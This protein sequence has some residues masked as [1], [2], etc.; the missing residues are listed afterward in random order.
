MTL[1]GYFKPNTQ[2][3]LYHIRLNNKTQ[4]NCSDMLKPLSILTMSL[5]ILLSANHIRCNPA[6]ITHPILQVTDSTDSDTSDLDIIE[7]IAKTDSLENIIIAYSDTIAILRQSIESSNTFSAQ[8]TNRADSLKKVMNRCERVA[9]SLSEI[10][11]RIT[12]INAQMSAQIND[13]QQKISTQKE[14]LDRQTIQLQEKDIIIG[15][16]ESLYKETVMGSTIDLIKLEGQ[17]KA[18]ETET[19]GKKRE[20]DLLMQTIQSSQQE[21]ERKNAEIV[22]MARKRESNERIIDSLRDSLSRA[23]QV[24][25]KLSQEQKYAKIE[26]ADLKSRLASRDKRDKHV[27]VVQGVAM[28]SYR[29]PLYMLA[30]KDVNNFNSYEITNENSGSFEFDLVTGAAVRLIKLSNEYAKY[31]T[32]IG[33]FVGFGGKNLFKN[34]YF[35]PNLKIFDFI[36][37]NAGINVAEFRVL[38]KGF[39]EG[40]AL[41]LGV[42]IPTVNKWVFN[43]YITLSF[44]FEIITQVAG[45]L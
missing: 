18:K 5:A 27:S 14:L 26:I 1:L 6:T 36:H 17:L 32:D 16:K 43:A 42:P 9:D 31:N 22:G 40:D 24:Y 12:P 25:V 13:L 10:C 38:K 41:P 29:T 21:I 15:Q 35:G 30:P 45:K 44:D 19:T 11:N 20:I 39:N 37:I 33:W 4:N 7:A 23:Q 28:R 34:F 2:N 8:I 3:K